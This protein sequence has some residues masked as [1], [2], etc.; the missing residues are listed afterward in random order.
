MVRL[1]RSVEG[2]T[3][4][5]PVADGKH[6]RRCH[7][8][9]TARGCVTR[10]VVARRGPVGGSAMAAATRQ[11]VS[12]RAFVAAMA[13][14]SAAAGAFGLSVREVRAAPSMAD[15]LHEL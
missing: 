11:I 3:T 10:D 14:I 4:L 5:I 6:S 15:A 9:D 2:T 7:A 12:R 1:S 8:D 13:S